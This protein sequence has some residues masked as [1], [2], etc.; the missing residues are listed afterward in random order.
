MSTRQPVLSADLRAEHPVDEV[1]RLLDLGNGKRGV[2]LLAATA[3]NDNARRLQDCQ[4]L[5]NVGLRH[6][7]LIL[8]R[9]DATLAFAEQ[10]EQVQPRGMREGLADHGLALED[11]V[12]NSVVVASHKL[13]EFHNCETE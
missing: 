11:F 10:V 8:Q 6:A 4:M 9:A 1:A 12:L 5:R 3:R 13:N 2:N 7:K